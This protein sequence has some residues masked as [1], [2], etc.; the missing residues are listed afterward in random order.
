MDRGPWNLD[1]KNNNAYNGGDKAR[2]RR[3]PGDG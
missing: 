1:E 3:N 2:G